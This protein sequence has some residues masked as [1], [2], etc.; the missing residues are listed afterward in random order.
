MHI[1]IRG[2]MTA[3]KEMLVAKAALEK[4]GHTVTLPHFT[5]HYAKLGTSDKMHGEAV[6]NKLDHDLIR[7]YFCLIAASNAVLVVNP[8]RNGVPGYIGANTFLEMGFAHV[9]RKPSIFSIQHRP[10]WPVTQ[11]GNGAPTNSPPCSQPCF[12]AIWPKLSDQTKKPSALGGGFLI[13]H[14]LAPSP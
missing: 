4:L 13:F 8:K 3:S 1:V 7:N 11:L 5:E 14:T 12:V 9:C 6:K 2:S 10:T